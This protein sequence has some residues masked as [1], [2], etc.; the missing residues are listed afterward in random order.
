MYPYTKRKKPKTYEIEIPEVM[1]PNDTV[2]LD[3]MADL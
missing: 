1:L 3:H 2:V